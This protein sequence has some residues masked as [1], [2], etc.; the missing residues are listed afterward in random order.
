[1]EVIQLIK[2][3]LKLMRWPNV[4]IVAL[5]QLTFYYAHLTPL[6]ENL[7][8]A[9]QFTDFHVALFVICSCLITGA[10]NVINDIF[11]IATDEINKPE[12]MIIG[13]LV[14]E[15]FAVLLYAG[16]TLTSGLVALYLAYYV[17]RLD[18][19]WIFVVVVF[20]LWF[21]SKTLKGVVII[22]NLTISLFCVGVFAIILLLESNGLQSVQDLSPQ[23]YQNFMQIVYGFSALAFL[24]TFTRE[25]V[26]DAEDVE[27]DLETGWQTL[28]SVMGL[29]FTSI[30][31]KGL[32]GIFLFMIGFWLYLRPTT[33]VDVAISLLGF[34]VPLIMMSVALRD[35]MNQQIYKKIS[36]HL[37]LMMLVAII[38]LLLI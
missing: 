26:K 32:I 36:L 21:Y 13:R 28:P 34:I 5:V 33:W 24:I 4:I 22:G 16:L 10:G 27:G 2:A 12:K 11:D 14:S 23:G 1:M 7:G 17:D 31:I 19:F 35:Y 30:V 25:I 37:K 29:K 18:W 6:M 15:K 38:Y 8:I 20:L 9:R 3:S